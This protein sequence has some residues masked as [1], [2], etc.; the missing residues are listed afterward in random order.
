MADARDKERSN[1]VPR[2]LSYPSL[3]SERDRDG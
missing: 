1:L 2:V 3:L